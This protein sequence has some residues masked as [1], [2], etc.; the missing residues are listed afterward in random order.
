MRNPSSL[1]S[2]LQEGE[3]ERERERGIKSDRERGGL[4]KIKQQ[5]T[6]S[7]S[8]TTQSEMRSSRLSSAKPDTSPSVRFSSD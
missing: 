1:S 6:I 3:R 4:H 2:A 5:N 7:T 8:I